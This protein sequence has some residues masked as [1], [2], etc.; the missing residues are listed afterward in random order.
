MEAHAQVPGRS[1][2]KTAP[3]EECRPHSVG[4]SNA[5]EMVQGF[6]D[7]ILPAVAERLNE[8]SF[9]DLIKILESASKPYVGKKS[10]IRILAGFAVHALNK[11]EDGSSHSPNYLDDL[12]NLEELIPV[13]F[14]KSELHAA[15]AQRL[16]E[17]SENVRMQKD[18]NR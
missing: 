16:H 9:S 11:L 18:N 15:V 6:W 1:D 8:F 14:R 4:L 12:A 5:S 7:N 17:V 13:L 2:E 10:V 3:H